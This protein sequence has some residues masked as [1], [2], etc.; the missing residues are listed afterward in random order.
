[1]LFK[2]RNTDN[3]L[4]QDVLSAEA[5]LEL[6]RII[7]YD[8]MAVGPHDLTGGI[9]L[10]VN[11][12]VAGSPW[13]SANLV[14]TEDR[15]VFP[16]WVI[17]HATGATIGILGLTSAVPLPKGY[18]I[19]KWEKTL[20]IYIQELFPVCDFIILLSNLDTATN[21]AIAKQYPQIHLIISAD[22][23]K[24]NL[25]PSL[26]R[27]TLITQTH[28]RGKY[29]GILKVNW[30]ELKIW[31][32]AFRLDQ[33][34]MAELLQ[35]IDF[36]INTAGNGN[37]RT[38][39]ALLTRMKSEKA[40]LEELQQGKVTSPQ[41]MFT[42]QFRSLT[43]HI[44]ESE[45]INNRISKLKKQIHES[46]KRS[47]KTH[48]AQQQGDSF[49]KAG[50]VEQGFAGATRCRQCHEKQFLRWQQTAHAKSLES[51]ADEQQHYNIRCLSC[52]VTRDMT[53]LETKTNRQYLLILPDE[54]RMVGCESCHGPART[55]SDSPDNNAPLAAVDAEICRRCHTS[56]M[57]YDFNYQEK[58][59]R[60]ACTGQ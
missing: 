15:P 10:L 50:M 36:Q 1:M 26:V 57:D 56:E 38:D 12:V 47:R 59:R 14:T 25:P 7:G 22:Q 13:I 18:K 53:T 3:A 55:H 44:H 17:R 5:I 21:E 43:R 35:A 58:L 27:N 41:G 45:V 4:P 39:N 46:N 9:E 40:R 23:R 42:F 6:Y 30:T 28:T 60:I 16:P 29:L 20:P 8:A 51:L 34:I 11:S 52:H 32:E 2:R 48:T 37:G 31:Q 33:E 49:T 54:L 24:G 19:D